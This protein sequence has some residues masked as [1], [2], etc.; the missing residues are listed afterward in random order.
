MAMI[1]AAR[2]Q[3]R[4]AG[5]YLYSDINF[6]I[7]GEIVR[8]VSGERLDVYSRKHIFAP[9]G[10]MSSS[11]QPSSELRTRIAPTAG[12]S[13]KLYWGEVHDA[14]ARRM[15]GIA[16]HAGLFAPVDDVALFA[17]LLL[18]RGTAD[19]TRILSSAAVARMTVRQSPPESLR[20]RGLGWDLGGPDGVAAF[21]FGSYGHFGFTGSMLWV[22][23]GADL[24][25][26]VLTN[27]VYPTGGGDAGPLRRAV[28]GILR[29]AIE[30][31]H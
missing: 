31:T 17:R 3:A 6:E 20:A 14:T 13:G 12:Q 9:L 11:F 1:L 30:R 23:P 26:I 8:R 2:L 25:A 22:L 16:G 24:Y 18:N 21:P 5:K 29:Q 10:M 19:G 28:I 15:G 27:R 7:L 4:P